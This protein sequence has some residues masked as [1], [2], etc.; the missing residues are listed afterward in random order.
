MYRIACKSRESKSRVPQAVVRLPGNLPQPEHGPLAADQALSRAR[1]L[2]GVKKVLIA[3]G[4]RYDCDRI[5]RVREGAGTST[6][7][8]ATSRSHPKSARKARSRR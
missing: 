5:A 4:V 6:T 7:S 3:S 2:K 1:E 8:V